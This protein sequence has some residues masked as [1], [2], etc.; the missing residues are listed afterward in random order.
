MDMKSKIPFDVN[1]LIDFFKNQPVR[2]VY[3]FG[4]Y[5]RGDYSQESDVDFLVE[6]ERS[7]DLFRFIKIKLQ[8]EFLLQKTVD[9]ISANGLSNRIK[10]TI[11]AEKVLIY[12]KYPDFKN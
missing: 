12:E 9:L 8:L 3:L 7:A 2:R 4:S 1:M 11:D 6:L 5:A 10:P